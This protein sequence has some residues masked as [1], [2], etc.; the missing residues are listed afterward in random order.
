[1]KIGGIDPSTLPNEEI[2]VLP[3]GNKNIV[4][5]AQGV[6]DL[7][8]FH[9]QVPEPK[10]PMKM[11][12]K[13]LEPDTENPNYKGARD[14]YVKRRMSYLVVASLKDIEW[15][16]VDENRP[17]TW[18]NWESDM[19]KAGLNQ[20]ECNLVFQLVLSANSLDDTKLAKARE[21]F[22]RGPSP[23]ADK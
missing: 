8:A 18:S 10:L 22:L 21:S 3:R 7:D 11:T 19:K 13:G 1:M 12:Q 6:P 9:A 5:R 15:D 20:F 2:L 23:T 4:F 14:E 16:T 17:G